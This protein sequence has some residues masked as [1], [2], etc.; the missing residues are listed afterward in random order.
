MFLTTY[1]CLSEVA[2]ENLTECSEVLKVSFDALF[3]HLY[4]SHQT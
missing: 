3:I 4:P 1:Q 2:S